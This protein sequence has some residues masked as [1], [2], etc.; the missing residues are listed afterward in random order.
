[1]VFRDIMG[2]MGS[3][4]LKSQNAKL[5]RKTQNFS[6]F[7]FLLTAFVVVLL[8]VTAGFFLPGARAD[9]LMDIAKQIEDL[10][11]ARELS[12]AA[13]TPLEAELI[14][15]DAKISGIEKQLKAAGQRIDELE[16]S[17]AEREEDLSI[18]YALLSARIRSYYKNTKQ[19][20]PF[21]LFFSSPH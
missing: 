12:V 2:K 15:L 14:K 5:Q 20:F 1:M 17:I 18:Q 9:E 19:F 7:R 11:R 16:E 6:L 10:S 8:V 21:L 3:S 13:T 4:K